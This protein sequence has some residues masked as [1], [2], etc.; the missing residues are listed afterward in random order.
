M[1]ESSRKLK[2]GVKS[3]VGLVLSETRHALGLKLKDVAKETGLS[4]QDIDNAETGHICGWPTYR[5]LL[6]F[7]GKEIKVELVDKTAE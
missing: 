2:N 7:Y 1:T 4:W 5:R 6:D 3:K